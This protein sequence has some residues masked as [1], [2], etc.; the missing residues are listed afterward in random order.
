MN[1]CNYYYEDG[2][3]LPTTNKPILTPEIEKWMQDELYRIQIEVYAKG[4]LD[5]LKALQETLPKLSDDL[6]KRE[7][8]MQ[9][10]N[11]AI[12]LI[13]EEVSVK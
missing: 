1:N 13:N 3:K 10:L 4:K 7:I 5:A 2:I 6:F 11:K 8:I 9:F 12:L